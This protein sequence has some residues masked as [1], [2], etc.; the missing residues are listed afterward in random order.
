MPTLHNPLTVSMMLPQPSMAHT[1]C[2]QWAVPVRPDRLGADLEAYVN[3][4]P[5]IHTLRL[6]NRFGI[7]AAINKLPT[8]L[9]NQIQDHIIKSAREEALREW[10]EQFQC[11][12]VQ[13]RGVNG[14]F[15]REELSE[16]HR[17]TVGC[18]DAIACEDR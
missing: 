12:E 6:C 3:T 14:N 4:L 5:A 16:L 13:C 1:D 17:G 18:D 11:W 8:E 10:S 15:T 7:G 2:S 9:V